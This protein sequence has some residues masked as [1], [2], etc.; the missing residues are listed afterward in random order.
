MR[1]KR[2]KA[3][4]KLMNAYGHTFGFRAPYQVL[5]DWDFV[6]DAV[7]H[8]ITLVSV[9]SK[10]LHGPIKPSTFPPPVPI[11]THPLL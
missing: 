9:L 4:K 6:L 1:A 11:Y 3:Y 2:A 8:K 10:V 5:L 7:R